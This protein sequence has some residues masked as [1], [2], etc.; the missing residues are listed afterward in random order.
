MQLYNFLLVKRSILLI[1]F[2]VILYSCGTYQY[3]GNIS[4]GIYSENKNIHSQQELAQEPVYE[5]EIKNSYYQ[6]VFSEKSM[7]YEEAKSLNDSVFTDVE[8]YQ[9]LAENDTIKKNYAPW[10]EDIDHLTINLYRGPAYNSIHWS[11]MW[12]YPIWLN[13]YGYGYG[14]VWNTWGYGYN[15]FWLRP[16]YYGGFGGYYNDFFNPFWS[17]GGYYGYYNPFYSN[18]YYNYPY[19]LNAWSNTSI[20][21]IS[22]GRRSRN[23]TSLRSSYSSNTTRISNR[24]NNLSSSSLRDR[25]SRIER[26][27]K[28]KEVSLVVVATHPLLFLAI[29]HLS[30]DSLQ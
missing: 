24:V 10:G 11:R 22:G 7:Q 12:N 15:N 9:G 20:A 3:S 16:Y 2:S 1:V 21:Y 5:K 8:N 26:I 17:W 18:H 27:N 4:D 14:S 30:C 23:A 6:T 29:F 19:F 25:I 28:T 13:N